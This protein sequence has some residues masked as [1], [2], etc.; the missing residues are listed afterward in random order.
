MNSSSG[1]DDET[2]IFEVVEEVE[3]HLGLHYSPEFGVS[4]SA[5]PKEN[6]HNQVWARDLAHAA[7]NYF[8]HVRPEAVSQ[9]LATIFRH[10]RADGMLPYRVEREYEMLKFLPGL[11]PFAKVAFNLIEKKI[12]GRTERPIYEGQEFGGG[13]DTIP[14]VLLAVHGFW[15]VS[16]EG[17]RF[18]GTYYAQLQ[19]AA[20][21]FEKRTDPADGLA[22]ITHHNPDWADTVKR[23]GKLGAI[24]VWWAQALRGL[25]EIAEGLGRHD[26]AKKYRDESERTRHGILEKLYA[27]EGYFKA[28][29]N[30]PRLDTVASIFGALYLLDVEEA[31]R[32]EELLARRV[33]RPTGFLNFD[34]P[35]LRREIFWAHRL[36]FREGEYHNHFVWPW[37]ALQNIYVKIKIGLEH[38]DAALREQYKKEAVADF[39]RMSGVFRAVDGAPEILQPHASAI[40][41][42][43]R[44]RV[45]RHF[46]GSLAGYAGIYRKLVKIGWISQK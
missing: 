44:Y 1:S 42:T 45:P 35:Y 9:S 24:N 12:F 46:M 22:I 31:V 20:S 11:R 17:K 30:D 33:A 14:V 27:P 4:P 32:V 34:P 6:Y 36:I 37:V 23:H 21:F 15:D 38:P 3:G 18:A 5:H 26:D 8:A 10:Q 40:P 25:A 29:V 39:V 41:E 43:P 16:D 7:G 13:E 19:K 2:L 28:E